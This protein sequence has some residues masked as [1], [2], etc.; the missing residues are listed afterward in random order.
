MGAQLIRQAL[1]VNWQNLA[2]G[3]Q[4]MKTHSAT[5]VRNPGLSQIYD[6]NFVFAITASE[7]DEIGHLL[8]RT[9]EEYAHMARL[10]FRLDPFTPPT[11]EARLALEHC[12]RSDAILLILEGR[13][14]GTSN[15]VVIQPIKDETSWIAYSELKSIDWQEYTSTNGRPNEVDVSQGFVLAS[16]LKCPPVEY[17]LAYVNGRPVGYCSASAGLEGIGQVEDLFVHPGYRHRGVGTP[18]L[19][20]CVEAARARGAS[21]ILIVVNQNNNAK[22]MYTA[23]GWQPLATCRQY[24]KKR[25][26]A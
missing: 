25:A 21:P 13:I 14:R 15:P 4:V 1:E 12:E 3:H 16:R 20:Y 8:T 19:R 11:F 2:L 17:V 9:E 7:Q 5:F 6:A 23:L 18:L 22:N 26:S 24:T 10:T